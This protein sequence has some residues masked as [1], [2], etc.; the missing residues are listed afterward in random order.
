MQAVYGLVSLELSIAVLG[1]GFPPPSSDALQSMYLRAICQNTDASNI[2]LEDAVNIGAQFD[3]NKSMVQN[4]IGAIRDA[5]KYVNIQRRKSAFPPNHELL[6]FTSV[7]Q[8]FDA[9]EKKRIAE[10]AKNKKKY[11]EALKQIGKPTPSTSKTLESSDVPDTSVTQ[12]FDAAEKKRRAESAKKK[13]KYEQAL[14]QIEK[15]TPS[16]S[17][18]IEILDD[19]DTIRTVKP[20]N[21]IGSES[22][23]QSTVDHLGDNR[24]RTGEATVRL[25]TGHTSP[26]LLRGREQHSI[27]YI[28]DSDHTLESVE[29]DLSGMF[30]LISNFS[31]YSNID[32][33]S[34]HAK[35][36]IRS[37]LQFIKNIFHLSMNIFS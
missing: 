26:K 20:A 28:E 27:Q 3:I 23:I 7:T 32:T 10:S 36:F 2:L 12:Q 19:S 21:T 37:H 5:C 30:T 34:Q 33:I 11:E 29:K 8:R 9:A 6:N 18:T 16:T 22:N 35:S 4:I 15:P 24:V 1:D 13:E 17:K 14:K 25:P 31:S